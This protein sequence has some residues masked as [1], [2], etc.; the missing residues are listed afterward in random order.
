M[1]G[2]GARPHANQRERGWLR[3]RGSLRCCAASPELVAEVD[4]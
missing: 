3:A 2:E 1:R 4:C